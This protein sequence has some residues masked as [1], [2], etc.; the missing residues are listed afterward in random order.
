M[1]VKEYIAHELIG[2]PLENLAKGVRDLADLPRRIGHPELREIYVEP[3]RAELAMSRLIEPSMN[4]IDVGAHLGSVLNLINRLAPHGNHFAIEPIPYKSKWLQ[5]KFPHVR[6]SSVALSNTEG[7]ASFYVHHH[8]SG[9]SGLAFHSS[10]KETDL[11]VDV[12]DVKLDKLDNIIPSD[13]PIGFIKLDVEGA[14]LLV[15]KGSEQVLKNHRPSLLF[16]C[17][18]TG[19]KT[20]KVDAK[21]IYHFFCDLDYNIF[22]IKDWLAG[23]EYLNCEKFLK[24]M[25]YPFQAFNY[26]AIPQS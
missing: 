3:A 16:E 19:L 21:E 14:E 1:R 24:S 17:S 23:G 7:Q 12:I 18:K 6:V 26:L 20:H 5:Q 15:L 9:F 4:C 25:E 2:T 22:L 10:G 13:V 11:R 8:L